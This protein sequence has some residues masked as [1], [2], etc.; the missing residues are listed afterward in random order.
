MLSSARVVTRHAPASPARPRISS[1]QHAL[2][3]DWRALAGDSRDGHVLLDGAHLILEA[4][5]AKAA[6][7][8]VLVTADALKEDAALSAALDGMPSVVHEVNASV[9]DAA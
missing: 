9:M 1:R 6:L 2:V 4:L 3:A 7:E 8:A 5:R